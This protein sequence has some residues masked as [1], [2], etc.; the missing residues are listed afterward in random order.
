[1]VVDKADTETD[2]KDGKVICK[3]GAKVQ[4]G[5]SIRCP[6]ELEDKDK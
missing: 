5:I 6:S 2:K 4:I 1:M 3:G